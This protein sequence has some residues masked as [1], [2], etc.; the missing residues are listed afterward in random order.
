M[1]KVRLDAPR[2]VIA[3]MVLVS[4]VIIHEAVQILYANVVESL[5]VSHQEY[6]DNGSGC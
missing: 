6:V 4:F 3:L 1:G 2:A 5:P